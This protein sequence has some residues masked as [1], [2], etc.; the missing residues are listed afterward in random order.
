MAFINSRT[1]GTNYV[2][3]RWQILQLKMLTYRVLLH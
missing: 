2:V 3:P 1:G